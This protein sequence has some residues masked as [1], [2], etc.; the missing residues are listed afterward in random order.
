MQLKGK[1][2]NQTW[3]NDKK[4]GFWPDF[5]PFDPNLDHKIFFEDFTS[6]RCY[7]LLH[8]IIVYNFKEK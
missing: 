7:T 3:D 2:I 4:P 1:L 8:A 6:T 5:G